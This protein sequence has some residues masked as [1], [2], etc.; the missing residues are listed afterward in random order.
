M[1]RRR[2]APCNGTHADIL[3]VT[4][5][6][7]LTW[8]LG[9]CFDAAQAD[10]AYLAVT[11]GYGAPYLFHPEMC[12]VVQGDEQDAGEGEDDEQRR[13]FEGEADGSDS[14]DD[15]NGHTQARTS[16]SR[17]LGS[18]NVQCNGRGRKASARNM[19]S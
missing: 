3:P 17:F 14:V 15:T 6:H 11:L 18:R 10:A 16:S 8:T 7:I 5:V 9:L 4:A 12:S 19:M 13:G 2:C 1:A